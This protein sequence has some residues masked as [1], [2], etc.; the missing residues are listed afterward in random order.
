MIGNLTVVQEDFESLNA[1]YRD[2]STNL[3]WDLVFTL[4]AWLKVWWQSFGPGAELHIR[5]VRR[6]DSIIGIA[7][8]QIRQDAASIIG[9]VDVCDYQ[10]FVIVPGQEKDFFNAVLD[11]LLN[12]GIHDLHLE[13][14]RP[15]SNVVTHLMPLAQERGYDVNYYRTDVSSDID[16]PKTWDEYL[17]EL[18]GKQ[19]HEVKRKMR[20]LQ[21]IGDTSFRCISEKSEIPGALDSFLKLF[22][23]SRGDKAQFMTESMQ[24]YFRSLTLTLAEM[25]VVC[26]GSLEHNSQPL[27]MVMYFDYNDSIYLY[28]SAYDPKYKSMSVGIISK[29][30][31]IKESIEHGKKKFDFL[32]GAERYKSYLGGREIPLYACHIKLP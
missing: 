20:N 1:F 21:D 2:P 16:L 31:C 29:A 11:D 5:S 4:P 13:T 32:K 25:G 12:K 10:D 9:N 23:E 14:I 7:P 19:R 18:D 8:L 3:R 28:N 27:A 17:A 26:F 22:P 15:D 6:G 24:A 30:Y